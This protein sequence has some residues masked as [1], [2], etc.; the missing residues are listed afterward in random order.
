MQVK[1][2]DSQT[3]VKSEKRLEEI[4]N[5]QRPKLI[6]EY[7]DMIDWLSMLNNNPRLRQT[8]D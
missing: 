8:E 7:N 3:L 5:I 4:K 1:C 2:L 6:L